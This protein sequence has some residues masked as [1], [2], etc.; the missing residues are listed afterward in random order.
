[1]IFFFPDR[2]VVS[3]IEKIEDVYRN[4][5]FSMSKKWVFSTNKINFE[6][7]GF[8][9]LKKIKFE[10]FEDNLKSRKFKVK[11]KTSMKVFP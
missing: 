10:K 6:L 9:N 5:V 3:W 2:I 11:N 4:H 7:F 1:M 8:L